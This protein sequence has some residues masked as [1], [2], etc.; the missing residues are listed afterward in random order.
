MDEEIKN[1]R[2]A[3]NELVLIQIRAERERT[4]RWVH[5]KF[6]LSLI[7]SQLNK[8]LEKCPEVE[9]LIKQANEELG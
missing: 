8:K 5:Q 2:A 1:L 3:I 9:V 7:A 4:V 6:I